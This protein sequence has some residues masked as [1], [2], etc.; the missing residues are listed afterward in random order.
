[1]GEVRCPGIMGEVD[2]SRKKKVLHSNGTKAC[3]QTKIQAFTKSSYG[4]RSS[5]AFP[6][7]SQASFGKLLPY[8]EI[9]FASRIRRAGLFISSDGV[10]DGRLQLEE[11]DVRWRRS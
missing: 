11:T 3:P 6:A 1:M 9:F 7:T 2:A 5:V 4:Q 10:G 8:N